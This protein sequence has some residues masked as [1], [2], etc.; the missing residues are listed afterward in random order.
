M[1]ILLLCT[2]SCLA[3]QDNTEGQKKSLNITKFFDF[4]EEENNN[5]PSEDDK[6]IATTHTSKLDTDPITPVE[7]SI[8]TEEDDQ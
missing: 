3:I 7:P 5:N 6:S 4:D 8:I 2:A 1:M